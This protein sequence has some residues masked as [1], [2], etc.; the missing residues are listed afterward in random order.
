MIT[1]PYEDVFYYK[2]GN[3]IQQSSVPVKTKASHPYSYDPIVQYH[4]PD[5]TA[6]SSAYTDRIFRWNSKQHD[7]LCKKHF[8]NIVQYWNDR[9]PSK[10]EEFMQDWCKNKNLKLVTVTEYCNQTT[11]YPTWLIEFAE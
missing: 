9:D 1:N 3:C 5:L 7:E 11:G 6:T 2:D 8:G 4:N 10:I